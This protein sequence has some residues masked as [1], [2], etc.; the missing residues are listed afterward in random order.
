MLTDKQ[1][2]RY[3]MQFRRGILGKDDDSR[4]QCFA[5]AAP[6]EALLGL[7]GIKA[8]LVEGELP[9]CNHF[10]LQLDD[11]RVLDP[12]ADQF[13]AFEGFKPMPPVYLGPPTAIHPQNRRRK[14][15]RPQQGLTHP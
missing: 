15:K 14:T 9:H 7:R 3:S 1:L 11:G 2:V 6:L 13:N 12:T 4:M 10:W 5:V 8:R